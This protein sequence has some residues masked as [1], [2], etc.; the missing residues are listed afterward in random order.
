MPLPYP[1]LPFDKFT[2]IAL[3]RVLK[4]A[5][6]FFETVKNS[7]KNKDITFKN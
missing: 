7:G 3:I 5:D 2:L 4:L 1:E 6:I